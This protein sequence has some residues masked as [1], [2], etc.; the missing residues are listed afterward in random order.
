MNDDCVMEKMPMGRNV[1]P[2]LTESLKSE[3]KTLQEKLDQLDETIVLIEA[4]PEIQK[5]LDALSK[6]GKLRNY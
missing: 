2:T 5:T 4:N 6:L 1:S 3:R